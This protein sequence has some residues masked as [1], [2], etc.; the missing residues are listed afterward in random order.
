LLGSPIITFSAAQ[1]DA[2]DDTRLRIAAGRIQMSLCH[3]RDFLN[4]QMLMPNTGLLHRSNCDLFDHLVG[5][6]EQC[7]RQNHSNFLR[8]FRI[9]R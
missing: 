5:A 6:D 2:S 4:K 9:D 3:H 8:R 1:D 7:L